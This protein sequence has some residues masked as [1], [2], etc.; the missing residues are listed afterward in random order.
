[1]PIRKIPL[2]TGEYYH[3]Y[4]RGNSKQQIFQSP[5]HYARFMALLYLANGTSPWAIREL[6][7]SQLFDFSRGE[8]QVAI[9]AYCLM[10]NH[11]HILLTP[12]TDSGVGNFMQKLSTGYSMY[13]N[14]KHNRTGSLYEGRFKAEHANDD[15]YLKYLFAYIHLNP[16]K[17][18]QND[19]R[20][21]GLHDV[22]GAQVFL[23]SYPYSSYIDNKIDR[24][25]SAILNRESYPDYFATK[26]DLDKEMMD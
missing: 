8:Q 23:D 4:N 13:F 6:D 14:A 19:W 3:I 15:R 1:M 24:P 21:V 5:E 11:F 26:T 10:P 9:G 20:D 16:V 17:L 2:V 18:F 25:E 12:L 7:D 22:A